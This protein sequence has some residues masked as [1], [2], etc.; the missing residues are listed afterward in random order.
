MLTGIFL[1][2]ACFGV[3]Y[4]IYW[5]IK[6][7]NVNAPEDQTGFLKM[8]LP[9]EGQNDHAPRKKWSRNNRTKRR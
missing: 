3:L 1:L 8:R 6:N 9:H 2:A 5:T 7:D 4:V